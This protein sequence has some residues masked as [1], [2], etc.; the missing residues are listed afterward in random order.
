[1]PKSRLLQW[2]V[3]IRFVW[4]LWTLTKCVA[5]A[6]NGKAATECLP[7]GQEYRDEIPKPESILGF[8]VGEWHVRHDLRVQYF[9]RL[10]EVST[11][12][13][14]SQFSLDPIAPLTRLGG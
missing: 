1:M 3:V 4:A 13:E 10:A 11:R 14:L 8:Q 2:V 9:P 7:P 12:I 5:G 6:A